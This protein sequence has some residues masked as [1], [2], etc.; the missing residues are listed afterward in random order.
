VRSFWTWKL[1][2][3]SRDPFPAPSLLVEG[4]DGSRVL[5]HIPKLGVAP[6]NGT[7]SPEQLVRAADS[8][9]QKGG[10]DEQLFPFGYGDWRRRP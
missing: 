2:W 9:L 3:Q 10:Y 6:Y 1:H 4:V 5:A 8:S 7:P